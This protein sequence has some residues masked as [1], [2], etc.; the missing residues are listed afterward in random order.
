MKLGGGCTER[1]IY[2]LVASQAELEPH[3]FNEQLALG[4]QLSDE[5]P[6]YNDVHVIKVFHLGSG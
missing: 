6:H 5:H 3:L 4:L 1:A 2:C